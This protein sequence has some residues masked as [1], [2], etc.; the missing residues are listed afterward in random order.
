MTRSVFGSHTRASTR[1]LAHLAALTTASAVQAQTRIVYVDDDAPAG[2]DG[3]SWSH[4]FNDLQD[5]LDSLSTVA[6]K[7][8]PAE[9]EI[10][11]AQGTY[12]PGRGSMDR[13]ASFQVGSGVASG[14]TLRMLGG[15]AGLTGEAP[16][17][18]D[19]HA[20]VSVLSGDLNNDDLPGQT[21]RPDNSSTIVNAPRVGAFQMDGFRVTG[22]WAQLGEYR[23][24]VLIGLRE[25]VPGEQD[26]LISRCRFTENTGGSLRAPVGVFGQLNSSVTA[27]FEDCEFIDN[28]G[29]DEGANQV[30]GAFLAVDAEIE[31]SRCQFLGNS[32]T[33]NGG[34]I[35]LNYSS[36]RISDSLFA[37]NSAGFMGGAIYSNG[38]SPASGMSLLVDR[39]TFF[40]NSA[41]DGAAA[42]I[43]A[44][45]F[46]GSIMHDGVLSAA[47][48]STLHI[49]PTTGSAK[50][51]SVER[52]DVKHGLPGVGGSTKNLTWLGGNIDADPLFTPATFALTPASPC[53]DAGIPF[54]ADTRQ[55]DLSGLRRFFDGNGDGLA[56][57]DMGALEYQFPPCIAD[58]DHSGFVDTDDFDAFIHAF[59]S[60]C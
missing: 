2:G 9:A 55:T 43:K 21:V 7:K 34:A 8:L 37:H 19:I 36:A 1:L 10:R 49:L 42:A 45:Q 25:R 60:G 16:D 50:F 52:C 35:L 41:P 6:N 22:G 54:A 27:R 17:A 28:M 33:Y 59:E 24:S 26:V 30:A 4:A 14:L 32:S 23:C 58:I 18:R 13:H 47:T 29:A 5:A 53:I 51:V 15:F 46:R 56:Q 20:Y 39:C 48:F 38:G 44:G 12:R 3:A 57:L 40:F 31:I 11:V